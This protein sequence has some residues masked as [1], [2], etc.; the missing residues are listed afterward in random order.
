M[1]IYSKKIIES[2]GIEEKIKNVFSGKYKGYEITL[3]VGQQFTV[4]LNFYGSIDLKAEAVKIFQNAVNKQFTFTCV[5]TYGIKANVNG[6]TFKTALNK[7]VGKLDATIEYLKKEQAP[8]V[9]HCPVCGELLET[10][11]SIRV[12][13]V[14][15]NLDE[16]CYTKLQGAVE[17]EQREFDSKPNNYVNGIFGAFLGAVIA[18]ILWVIIY[19]LGYMSALTAVLAVFLGNYFYVKFGGKENNVK[20]IIVAVVSLAV[21]VLTCVGL[22]EYVVGA[23]LAEAKIDISAFEFIFSNAEYKEAFVHDMVMNVVFTLIG[24]VAQIIYTKRKDQANKTT[25]SK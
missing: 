5:D 13:E 18:A 24:V 7:L 20:N 6:M 23:A 8:G 9:G 12:N 25:I 16:K 21:L 17:V 19:F 22:Y 15:V 10:A 2:L 1:G 4:Y 14:Y 3:I 11:H